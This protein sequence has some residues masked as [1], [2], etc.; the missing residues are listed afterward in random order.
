MIAFGPSVADAEAYRR[1]AEPGIRRAA[2]ADSAVY[3]FTAVGTICRGYN[4][5]L[6]APPR[7][8]IWRR[9]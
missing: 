1:Y 6:D 3:V 9:W 7:T 8:T 4:L 5:L 2:E